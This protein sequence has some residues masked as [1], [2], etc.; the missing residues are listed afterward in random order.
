MN[1]LKE[2]PVKTNITELIGKTPSDL[3]L[4]LVWDQLKEE[5]GYELDVDDRT[6]KLEGTDD[7]ILYLKN[8]PVNSLVS[9]FVN[10]TEEDVGN[11]EVYE[12]RGIEYLDGIFGTSGLRITNT[13]DDYPAP[14]YKVTYNSGYSASNFPS[15]LIFA[16]SLIY[17]LMEFN[18][19]SKADLESYKIQKISYKFK[20]QEKQT[21]KISDIL[22]RFRI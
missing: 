10:D 16:S 3:K 11:F 8:R 22:D 5:L 20:D 21:K 6:E 7:R 18:L 2:E 12:G 1:L 15:S 19:S 13:L 17:N 9:A 4:D 14:I